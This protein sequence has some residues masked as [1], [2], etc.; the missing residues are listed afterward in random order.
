MNG[1]NTTGPNITGP[2]AIVVTD[3]A[4]RFGHTEVLRRVYLR[5]APGAVVALLGPSGCGKTTLLRS[6]A[7]LERLD[8]GE[9]RIGDRLVSGPGVH[10]PPE[11]RRVGMVFQD[12]A[13]FPHLTVAQNVAYGL[14]RAER[15][16]PR[17][18]A[19]LEM[20]GLGGLGG[21]IPGTLSGG[22]QQRVAL[23][24]AL[25]P[26]P[27][28]LLLDEPFSNLD[29]ALRAQVRSEVHQLLAELAVTTVFVTHD[30]EEAFVLGDEV[31]VMHGGRIVQQAPPSALYARPA[32]PWVASFVGDA[33]LVDGTAAGGTAETPI[34]PV[35]LEPAP[36]GALAG[37][38]QVV[39]RPEELRLASPNGG[40]GTPAVV[41]LCEYYGHDTVYLVRPD[42]AEPLRARAGSVPQFDR[43]DRVTVTY[44]GPPAVA[45]AGRGADS[46]GEPG[47]D[48]GPG[49][50]G[51]GDA[52]AHART[53]DVP[54]AARTGDAPGPGGTSDA[55]PRTG[56]TSDP[57][58]PAE[59]QTPA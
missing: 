16:G 52:A 41:E 50:V 35:A 39:L 45:Y 37:A 56:R 23:A 44:Q 17:V 4:K 24:R 48:A 31:A 32:M 12:W 20:V 9:V 57:G 29:T 49:A 21:R 43:G 28:V 33:N 1:P 55:G 14:P 51:T 8:D 18:G 7:G 5:V 13:L 11:R 25:A 36:E 40:H 19:A 54:G 53:S 3:A 46:T 38:V 59:A 15:R 6:I 30:Q 22:Q 47:S 26:Q 27:G 42:G 34:G 10:V 58:V 2:N